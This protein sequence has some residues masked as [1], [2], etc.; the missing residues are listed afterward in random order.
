MQLHVCFALGKNDEGSSHASCLENFEGEA[1]HRKEP[2][3]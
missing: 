1:V 2:F 3:G